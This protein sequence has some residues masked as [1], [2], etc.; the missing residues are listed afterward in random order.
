MINLSI[1]RALIICAH[2]DDETLGMGASWFKLQQQGVELG[3]VWFTDGAGARGDSSEADRK[4]AANKAKNYLAPSYFKWFDFPDNEMDTVSQLTV[5]KMIETAID[6]FNPDSVFTHW[7]GDLNIDH[8]IVS[9]SVDVACRPLPNS[10]LKSVFQFEVLSSSE[11]SSECFKPNCYI[12]VQGFEQHK[13]N[14]LKLY[15][16]ELKDFPHPRS[17]QSVIAKMQIRGS[18]CGV[19]SAESFVVKRVLI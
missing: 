6:E 17:E 14:A 10:P 16:S 13:L 8:K 1:Q 3:L 15:A 9:T 18:E 7:S 19:K 2:P 11:W 12:D 5:N 4:I